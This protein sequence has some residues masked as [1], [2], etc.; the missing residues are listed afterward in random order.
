VWH[1][2]G[3][4]RP[5]NRILI[6]RAAGTSVLLS[7]LFVVVYGATNW[8][9]AH[10]PLADVQT[11][12]FAWEL[13]FIPFAPLLIVPYMSMDV[14]F[15]MA[16]FLCRDEREL[17]TFAFRV[18][19]SILVAAAFFLLLPLKLNW[20][21][22]PSVGGWFGNFVEQSCTAPFLMEYPH[23]LFPSLH[24]VLC[25]LVAD[26]YARHSRGIA[27]VLLCTWFIL[28]GVA[29]LLTWQHHV[30]DI[31]GGLMLAGFA[32]YVLR[33]SDS[34]CPVTPN[35]RVGCYYA[36]G[37]LL[38]LML[39]KALGLW[40]AFLLWPAAGLGIA[41]GAYFGF[42]PGIFRKA[43][44][45]LPWSTRFVLAPILTGQY[46]SLVYYRR[47]CR[48]WDEVV[49]AILIGRTLTEA[50]A[51]E[52]KKQGVTAVLDLTAEFSE[53]AAFRA[54]RYRNLPILDLTAPT[55]DQLHQAAAFIAEESALGTVFVH[56]KIGYSRSAAVVGA[57]LLA[58][59]QA[60]TI[61]EAFEILREAR[62]SIVIR[63]EVMQSLRAFAEKG[64][65]KGVRN[66]LSASATQSNP[67]R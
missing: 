60:G 49:P 52:A 32:F 67:I 7:L 2:H 24:I 54:T 1:I 16:T 62:P 51:A 38:V 63:P 64:R 31:A 53:V 40:G 12:Y 5:P 30:V 65:G 13:T 8:L 22:R 41:A 11:W 25:L 61:D 28:I 29:T 39:A 45:R 9:T 14:F 20:P 3:V 26:I 34:R 35:V 33:D 19:F 36:T 66:R 55:Q 6:V 43:G 47:Q 44:G 21:A 4:G 46:L 58:S 15:F 18:V 27:R 42:G 59:G 23:N 37:A 50:E 17:R 56:C 57:Y 48:A 10:R